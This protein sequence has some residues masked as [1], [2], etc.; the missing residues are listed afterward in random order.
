MITN[1]NQAIDISVKKRSN[2]PCEYEA[3]FT[4]E[5]EDETWHCHSVLI[6]HRDVLCYCLEGKATYLVDNCTYFKR[7]NDG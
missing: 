2:K 7:V 3:F 1:L 5:V 6:S 4:L